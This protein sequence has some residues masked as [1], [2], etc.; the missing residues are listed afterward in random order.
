M[1]TSPLPLYAAPDLPQRRGGGGGGEGGQGGKDEAATAGT[2]AR[3]RSFPLLRH[4][5]VRP[6]QRHKS[7]GSLR[8]GR[9]AGGG[10]RGPAARAR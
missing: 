4:P 2:P 5:R 3:H 7:C 9:G 6:S 10:T 1:G 8:G